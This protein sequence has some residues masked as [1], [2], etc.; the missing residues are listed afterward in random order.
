MKNFIL[1]FSACMLALSMNAQTIPFHDNFE[2]SEDVALW[3]TYDLNSDDGNW[4][5]AD[6][7]TYGGIGY[8][9]SSCFAYVYSYQNSGNDWLVSPGL[10]LNSGTNYT[11]SFKYAEFDDTKFE[12]LQVYIGTD[13]TPATFTEVLVTFDSLSS[14]TWQTY[15]TIYSPTTS[16]NFYLAFYAYSDVD[17][18]AILIDEFDVSTSSSSV[19]ESNLFSS[20]SLFPNPATHQFCI[21][22]VSDCTI[23]IYDPNGKIVYNNHNEAEKLFINTEEYSNGIYFLQAIK[24]GYEKTF[25]FIVSND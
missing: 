5:W 11:I 20:V 15:S 10:P 21:N 7:A 12:K 18:G 19:I 4:F 9:Q 1:L 23:N 2:Y 8:Q 3:T 13:P 16:G 14:T 25:K 17:Q 22:N 6:V 24:N